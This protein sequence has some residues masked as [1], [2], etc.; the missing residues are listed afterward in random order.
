MK[1]QHDSSYTK[2]TSKRMALNEAD[3]CR[4]HITPKLREVGWEQTP[5]SLTEQKIFTD[6]RVF[7]T[8][9]VIR[10]GPQKRADYL[11]RFTR[12]F[13][14]AVVEA[15]PEDASAG[16]GLQQAKEYAEILGLKFAY[17]TNGREIIEFDFTTG[18][19]RE[20][21]AFPSPADLWSRLRAADGIVDDAA[22]RL[23]TP[24][25]TTSS[26][27]PHYYQEI[28]INRAVQ[29]IL[30]GRRRVLLTMATGTGK[31]VVAF[32]V[33]WKLWE[34]RWNRTGEHRRPRILFLA[35]R[36]VL[37]DDPKDKTFAPFGDARF[38]IE[39]GEIS[40]SREMYFAIYQ[41]I[42]KDERRPGLY[43]EYARDFFD[44]IIVDECHRGAARD[45]SNWREIL[46]YFEPAYQLGMTATPLREDNRNTYRYFGD[47][48][49]TYSLKQGIEDGFLAPYRVHRVVT[50]LDAAGWRPSKGEVDRYGREIPDAE[51]TTQDFERIIALRARTEAI[52]RH[53]TDFMKRTDR[54]GKTIVFCV[55]Q[56]HADD[57]RRALNNL[58]ADL[59]AQ[60]PDYVA[61][62]TADEGTIGRGYLGRFQ[63]LETTQPI[64]LT[65][66]QLLTTGVDAPT[67]KNVVLARVVNS[68]TE[69][70]QIIGRGTRLREDYG[71]LFFNIIDYTG[72]A[73]RQFADP[74]FDG[75]PEVEHE[76]TVDKEGNVV[77]DV[78]A[79]ETLEPADREESIG[80][81]ELVRIGEGNDKDV[82]SRK[83]Y[84]DGG[85]VKIA[86]HLVYELDE[87][88]R[89]LRVVQY[90]DYTAE[91]VRT[92][93]RS[94]DELKDQWADPLKR[95]EVLL[96]LAE[97]GIN[98]QALAEAAGKPEADPF[99]LLCHLAFH[100]PLRT[101]KERAARLREEKEFFAQYGPEAQRILEALLDKYSDFGPQQF[102]IPDIL[103][104]SPFSG[105]GNVTEIAEFFG[106]A[107]RLREAVN[108]LQTRLYA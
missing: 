2:E 23:L 64:I 104:V 39:S 9:G 55:N 90:T 70:K 83:Y 1:A 78:D 28:A 94:A 11:L 56:E 96:A 20:L 15:K 69:F 99:D 85:Q 52:A 24:S 22:D 87:Q 57:M 89:Q 25:N 88:G 107:T 62:V 3:T 63:E 81:A 13:A 80:D 12:D 84:V 71:K 82:E 26:P 41:A 92:L 40:K 59:T 101:R 106:G 53:L 36:N 49:Y 73:T 77:D 42:A 95:E 72:S 8:G 29:S 17:A 19:E 18:L 65:T 46:E 76:V 38:K 93:F 14:I 105:Y 5:H 61:R 31:T 67:C 47:P 66:S 6:G 75:F 33:A 10:R 50:E 34:S 4:V 91:K 21:S 16:D 32:Q 97:R 7:T 43:K 44:L 45:E 100:A 35:D 86:A 98:F 108:D 48:I 60:H 79:S 27:T 54:F 103:L 37:V 74:N 58:N 51:Y 68:M 102:V 30:Q